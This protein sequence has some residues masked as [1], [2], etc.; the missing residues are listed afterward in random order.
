MNGINYISGRVAGR[1]AGAAAAKDF[2]EAIRNLPFAEQKRLLNAREE[3]LKSDL[4][5]LETKRSWLLAEASDCDALIQTFSGWERG[6][7]QLGRLEHSMLHKALDAAENDRVEFG[8]PDVE[9]ELRADFPPRIKRCVS[10]VIEHDWAA[11]FAGAANFDDGDFNLPFDDVAFEMRVDGR[12]VVFVYSADGM[13]LIL[14]QF[15]NGW[16]VM[17]LEDLSWPDKLVRAACIALD[18]EIAT[19]ELVRE[20]ERLNRARIKNGKTPIFAHHVIR[21]SKK[22]RSAL[23]YSPNEEAPTRH[24]RLHFV[25]G[26]WRHFET[27]RTW[28]KW[29][30]RGNPDIGFIDKGYR[31]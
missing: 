28:I 15:G 17:K 7:Y 16:L 8:N 9:Q 10:F 13:K 6:A 12:C 29:H 3:S 30:L 14:V 19:H 5:E 1:A 2:L 22:S 20:P 31:L 26:H 24:Y 25:R 27:H 4:N 21:L 11:A 23:P 18:A